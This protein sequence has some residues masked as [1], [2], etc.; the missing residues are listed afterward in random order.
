MILPLMLL[1]L[2]LLGL[3]ASSSSFYVHANYGATQS[4]V[5]TL[6]TRM[7]AEAGLQKVLL[8]LRDKANVEMLY[9]NPEELHRVVVWSLNGDVD[10]LGTTQE[11]KE[12]VPAFRFSIVADDPLDDEK[13]VRF[14]VTDE[15][16]KI[17]L[18]VAS[19]AQLAAL[20]SQFATEEMNVDELADALIDWRDTDGSP[21]EFGV[22]QDFYAQLDPPYQVK[23]GPFDTVEELLL[24]RGFTGQ[25][26]YGE[27]Y[28]RNGLMS[29]NEDDGEETFPPDDGDGH[30]NRGLCSAVTVWS[31][32]V[33]TASD[34][35][36]R[37]NLL[38]DPAQVAEQLEPFVDDP[39]KREF[40]ATASQ[41]Q[42]RPTSLADLLNPRKNPETGEETPSPIKPEDLEW[43][44]DRCTLSSSGESV[45]LI[46]VNSAPAEVL[47]T[48]GDLTPDDVKA[49]LQAR[50]EL[51][52]EQRQSPGWVAKVIGGEKYAA[53]ASQVTA[54]G[55]RFRVESLGYG[56]H[57][58]AVTR[59]EAIVEMRGPIA[60]IIYYRDL[61]PLGTNYPFRYA[62]GDTELV[63]FTR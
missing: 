22:E 38:G 50:A 60:Q 17:N 34:N 5:R 47:A 30:L 24:V 42:P 1:V 16:S 27:D 63:G 9:H 13:L 21:R 40:L 11:F 4:L 25:L 15:S 32:D 3:L 10:V 61:T 18:N 53:M 59:L 44:A 36:P 26:L 43:I 33:N 37:V 12:G 2:I 41:T 55:M 6:D 29:P 23:N 20:I 56:D 52:P 14:G 48:L 7:A 19:R 49:I 54:R 8:M 45:G 39:A 51:T 62:E 31:R 35:Q 46:N 58:G 28:D 57:V